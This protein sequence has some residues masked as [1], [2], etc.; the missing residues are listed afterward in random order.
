M[1]Q[2]IALTLLFA[3]IWSTSFASK[4]KLPMKH[5]ARRAT[6]AYRHEHYI[7]QAFLSDA[8]IIAVKSE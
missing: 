2:K 7:R 5:A 3:T 4:A 1:G 8:M 6:A